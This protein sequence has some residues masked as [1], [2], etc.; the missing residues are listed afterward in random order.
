MFDHV[1]YCKYFPNKEYICALIHK[2]SPLQY[3]KTKLLII[4]KIGYAQ[5]YIYFLA[6]C[7]SQ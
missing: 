6:D 1:W 2:I 4:N 3:N 7:S 5:Q